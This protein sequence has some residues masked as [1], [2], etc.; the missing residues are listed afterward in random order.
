M[1]ER[2]SASADLYGHSKGGVLTMKRQGKLE[3]EFLRGRDARQD[4][5][6]LRDVTLGGAI[7]LLMVAALFAAVGVAW[8]AFCWMIG[9]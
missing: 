3:I 4:A 2:A 1:G 7:L 6:R 9:G 5:V 8:R